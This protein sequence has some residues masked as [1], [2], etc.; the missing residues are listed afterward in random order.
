MEKPRSGKPR[1][2]SPLTARL[3]EKILQGDDVLSNA[4]MIFNRGV[5]T[6]KI[7]LGIFFKHFLRMD[8]HFW[9]LRFFYIWFRFFRSFVIRDLNFW[10]ELVFY[11][12]R[13]NIFD[14][15]Y[16]THRNF[17]FSSFCSSFLVKLGEEM[18]NR[19]RGIRT[20]HFRMD[21]PACSNSQIS[22]PSFKL[23][24]VYARTN[25]FSKK[26]ARSLR[27]KKKRWNETKWICETRENA[28]RVYLERRNTNGGGIKYSRVLRKINSF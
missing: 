14:E 7:Y 10:D 21:A 2:L 24:Y 1:A 19:C 9:L 13:I 27:E 26:Y 12:S 5:Q 3:D 20:Y 22:P 17:Q 18:S 8:G 4:A 23:R 25:E 6:R 15:F 16:A 11:I 28:F